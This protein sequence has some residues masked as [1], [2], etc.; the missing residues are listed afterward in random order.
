MTYRV[1]V[2]NL[3]EFTAKRGDLDLRFTPSPSAQEGIA[4]HGIVQ[5]RRVAPYLSELSLSGE[6]NNLQVVG[7]A[8][9]YDPV[10]N[11]LEEIKTYRGDF[12]QI[13]DNHR[14]LHWAQVKIYGWMLCQERGL[15][16]VTLAL[17]YFDIRSQQETVIAE[18]HSALDLKQ[19]FETQ[20]ALF[21]AWSQSELTHR[22]ARDQA[23]DA[24]KFPYADFR[25][26]QRALAEDVYRATISGR[27]LMV[28]A[29]TGIG[30]TVGTL[31]PTLKACPGQG[32]DKIFFLAAK[33][34]G[35]SLALDAL[36]VI[37]TTAGILPLR[38]LE[39]VARDK[40]C[41]HP[42]KACHG[43]SCPLA[44]GFYD[45][46]PAARQAAADLQVMNRQALRTVALA[47][48]V[49]PYYLGQ[50]MVRWSD[51]VVG[52]YNYYFDLNA[53]LY[54]LTVA[55]QWRV[56]VLVDEAHNMVER[57][58]NMYTAQLDQIDFNIARREAPLGL[59]K[60][61]DRFNRH[62]NTFN[63]KQSEENK[64]AAYHVCASIPSTFS[65]A[66][67]QVIN[68][69]S[70]YMNENPLGLN[71]RLL[72]SYFDLLLFSNLLASFDTHSIFDISIAG[73]KTEKMVGKIAGQPPVT[74]TGK[75]AG[76]NGNPFQL[77]A[78]VEKASAKATVLCVRNIIPAPFLAQRFAAAR[79]VVMFSATLTPLQF[80][81]DTLGMPENT[82]WIE[83]QSPFSPDQLY[84]QINAIST[85]Y[86]DRAD[87]L[88]PIAT[89]IGKTYS[90]TP[91]NYLAFFS[92]FDYLQ[93]VADLFAARFPEIP[94][95]VQSRRMAESEREQ[96]LAR[97]SPSAKGVGFAVL[98]GA[99]AEGID[100]PGDCLIGAFIATLGLPP[101][102]P[103]NAQVMQCMSTAF[104]ADAGYDYTYLFP[105]I[106]KV[107]QA[108][109][110]VI[111]SQHDR[112][113]VYLIDD[114]FAQPNVARLLPPWWNVDLKRIKEG[115][116]VTSGDPVSAPVRAALVTSVASPAPVASATS[117][118]GQQL[119]II[120]PTID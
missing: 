95:W 83:V 7:R 106:R 5:S 31:F 49:C 26:G 111:R 73:N 86:Q 79:S 53:M 113:S 68:A 28:Q 116:A 89:L 25:T 6:I 50:D 13:P 45:R 22:A 114:R 24:L 47:H 84:V 108:A 9:G 59:K 38:V 55:N 10:T 52:D 29:P 102:N 34:S 11:Q 33:T 27:C 100:L 101:L 42:D 120:F 41:E 19:F 69:L 46:L 115:T 104:G 43:D 37:R 63:K 105:G 60:P 4:G 67:Q 76:L 39:L 17:V 103:V 18:S 64:D 71:S 81:S 2:R 92:S 20:C 94:I 75:S 70:E 35:R 14:Q 30:K 23:L 77:I 85:R 78:A 87:S 99:F 97:F 65:D 62:W 3:C 44:H 21:L 16:A 82:A 117:V 15:S 80:Y 56:T 1:T 32:V 119:G 54:G 61:L 110:R 118:T 88:M 98:G 48:Q 93:K 66:L 109:G 58:R 96:F 57:V 8:D 112:G 40:A 12:H 72:Q 107:V 91:G 90:S 51:V 74:L 36:N